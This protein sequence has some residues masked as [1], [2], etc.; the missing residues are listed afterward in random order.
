MLTKGDRFSVHSPLSQDSAAFLLQFVGGSEEQVLEQEHLN[1]DQRKAFK[2]VKA[3]ESAYMNPAS[4][5]LM[6][7]WSQQLD[8]QRLR[9][10]RTSWWNIAGGLSPKG[11]YGRSPPEG[12]PEKPPAWDHATIWGREKFP[13]I[14]VSQPYPWMLNRDIKAFNEF[15]D[16]YGLS[17]RISNFPSWHYPGQCWFIEWYSNQSPNDILEHYRAPLTGR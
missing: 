11:T 1:S 7:V 5:K 15:G 14:A 3:G 9:G 8:V 12:W 13:L 4:Q 2:V 10:A 17:F 16:A 6:R